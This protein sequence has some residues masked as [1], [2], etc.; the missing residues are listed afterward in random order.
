MPLLCFMD[1]DLFTF[2]F[3]N[4][5]T[6]PELTRTKKR[7]ACLAE[8]TKPTLGELSLSLQDRFHNHPIEFKIKILNAV[9]ENDND[10]NVMCE[11]NND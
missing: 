9:K 1:E 10:E 3:T 2:R 7:F 6:G 8:K 4:R 5:P 11:N